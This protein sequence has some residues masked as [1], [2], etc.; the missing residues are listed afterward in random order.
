MNKALR[1]LK[2]PQPSDGRVGVSA[3]ASG[4]VPSSARDFWGFL[5]ELLRK[6][7]IVVDRPRG[8]VHP[9][10]PNSIYPL[11]Y[12][13]LQRT[14][15]SDEA[16]IDVWLGSGPRAAVQGILCSIDRVKSDAE[17]KLLVGCSESEIGVAAGFC[18]RYQMRCLVVRRDATIRSARKG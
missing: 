4:G 6:H 8:S 14:R 11:D 2:R 12:G 3:T 7:R 18:N 1:K 9:R 13:Y 15:S 5:D 17:I 16:G 10:Y